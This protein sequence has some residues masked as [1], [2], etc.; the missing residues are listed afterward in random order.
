[1]VG[2]EEF[3]GENPV[4][5]DEITLLDACQLP[6]G[7]SFGHRDE[8]D[9]AADGDEESPFR[10]DSRPGAQHSARS[11]IR[12]GAGVQRQCQQGDQC[13]YADQVE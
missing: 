9:G 5:V 13:R 1:M 8:N 11:V 6:D 7:Q 12:P 10:S 2:D 4:E 3:A